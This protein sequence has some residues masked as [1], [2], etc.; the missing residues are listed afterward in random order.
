MSDL[1][2]L[3]RLAV[4]ARQQID[5]AEPR[6]ALASWALLTNV[7]ADTGHRW[8]AHDQELALTRISIAASQ[9]VHT[10]ELRAWIRQ[11]PY[12][13]NLLRI[14]RYVKAMDSPADP[15]RGGQTLAS[16]LWLVGDAIARRLRDEALETRIDHRREPE[17]AYRRS[18][19][20]ID[21]SR[22]IGSAVSLSH[23]ISTDRIA[24][25]GPVALETAI[26]RWEIVAHRALVLDPSSLIVLATI[27]Q[28][29]TASIVFEGFLDKGLV[30]GHFEPDM[31]ERV[32][33][34]LLETEKALGGLGKELIP[35]A[36]G[37][38][39]VPHQF[40]EAATNLH[41]CL[42]DLHG[43]EFSPEA[44]RAAVSTFMAT[45]LSVSGVV[46]DVVSEHELRIPARAAARMLANRPE[47]SGEAAVVDPVAIHRGATIPLPEPC[48][49]VM[50][51]LATQVF[52]A[53]ATAHSA[54]S[55]FDARST[56]PPSMATRPS[57]RDEHP[58]AQ[59][60]AVDIGG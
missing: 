40:L 3:V 33:E 26:G 2:E 29:R 56:P 57:H 32:R 4:R 22:R 5:R 23:A 14:A 60:M 18:W 21:A 25:D 17:E 10:A 20:L 45:N 42:Q 53:C 6:A 27:A 16:V 49:E 50:L 39:Q 34:P 30:L 9:L 7:M 19:R 46:R 41:E 38:H 55:Q 44:A 51:P 13:P 31:V 58:L 47:G 8:R 1:A 48:R 59:E 12:E 43:E 35:L 37:F 15:H 36:I 11:T 54:S 28:Q 52:D 24:G